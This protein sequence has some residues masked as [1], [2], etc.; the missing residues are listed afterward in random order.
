VNHSGA[1][2]TGSYIQ[3]WHRGIILRTRTRRRIRREPARNART[4]T[5][6]ELTNFV[7]PRRPL[8]PSSLMANSLKL[9]S[10]R[11]ILCQWIYDGVEYPPPP[12]PPP[13]LNYRE[14]RTNYRAQ[15]KTRETKASV[16]ALNGFG[17]VRIVPSVPPI[18]GRR[19]DPAIRSG[20]LY[21]CKRGWK[22]V[23]VSRDMSRQTA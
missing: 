19:Y 4:R 5:R 6:P 11:A 15:S 10:P 23:R 17:H 13:L 16:R 9:G 22:F 14:L 21:L 20:R 7:Q 3:H 2:P 8:R 12:P 18:S 1:A